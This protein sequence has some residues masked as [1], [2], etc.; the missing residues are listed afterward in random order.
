MNNFLSHFRCTQCGKE[1]EPLGLHY[2]CDICSKD[3]KPGMPLLGVLE[4]MF[5]YPAIAKAWRLKPDPL[6]FSAVSPQFYP[7]IPVG[8]TPY[9]KP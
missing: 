6:L 9:F 5:D 2:L 1:F 8:N 3:Y 4:A 7:P